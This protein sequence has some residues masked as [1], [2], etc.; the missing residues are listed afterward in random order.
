ML[1]ARGD[2][3]RRL[4]RA[5]KVFFRYDFAH[6]LEAALWIYFWFIFNK[7]PHCLEPEA[8]LRGSE[9]QYCRDA[10][11]EEEKSHQRRAFVTEDVA[12]HGAEAVF[13]LYDKFQQGRPVYCV[14]VEELQ[15]LGR[16]V[17]ENRRN[18]T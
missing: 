16:F 18:Q 12:S 6:D 4:F 7:V 9:V 10:L 15:H 3:C 11:L 1:E 13:E 14:R 5:P 8:L 17:E 2:W